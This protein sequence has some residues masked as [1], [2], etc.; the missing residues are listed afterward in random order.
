[1]SPLLSKGIDVVCTRAKF[2][3]CIPQLKKSENARPSAFCLR[4]KL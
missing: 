3:Q 4:D 1:M 2:I